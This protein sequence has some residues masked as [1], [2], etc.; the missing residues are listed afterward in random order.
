MQVDE[1]AATDA[2]VSLL[3]PGGRLLLLT[4]N[5]DEP[6]ERGPERLRKE[7]LKAAFGAR[8]LECEEIA[9]FR[10]DPTEAYRRQEHFDQPPL[11]WRSVWRRPIRFSSSPDGTTSVYL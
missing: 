5:A 11:G 4:G 8:G 10:F 2:V 9:A 6:A 3:K 1:A 7:D